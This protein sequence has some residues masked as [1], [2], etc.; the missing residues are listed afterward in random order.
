MRVT[1]IKPGMNSMKSSDEL[2]A[3]AFN[4]RKKWNSIPSILKLSFNVKANMNLFRS[5]VCYAYYNILFRK[6]VFKK[7]D[8]KLGK[9]R[10]T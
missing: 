1:F 2:T 3:A 10:T 8:M 7:Q 5:I 6:E 9:E 4:I